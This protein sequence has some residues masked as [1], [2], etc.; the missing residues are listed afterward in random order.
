[1]SYVFSL[2]KSDTRGGTGST[3]KQGWRWGW[4][5]K[6]CI[7]IW[8]NVKIRK[9]TPF[10]LTIGY[11]F[12][13]SVYGTY[14][15]RGHIL[16]HKTKLKTLNMN[17][18]MISI[19]LSQKSTTKLYRKS[20]NIQ[21]WKNTHLHGSK[22]KCAGNYENILNWINVKIQHGTAVGCDCNWT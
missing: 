5:R 8:V 9:K 15:R 22:S 1:M 17:C 16:G 2:T 20:S 13:S 14:T 10:L 7:H 6:Q 12:F 11:T 21:K 19:Q 3:Q 18:T 4:W